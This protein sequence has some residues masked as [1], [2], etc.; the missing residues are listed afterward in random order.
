M[1]MCQHLAEAGEA[2][3][4][5]PGECAECVAM[6]SGWVHLRTCLTCGN[7]GCCDSSPQRHASGHYAATSHPV[8]RSAQP[9]ET[10]RW[11]FADEQMG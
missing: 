2:T 3:P 6:G 5:T 4:S 7:V 11:C 1:T 8:V 9:G 10:W